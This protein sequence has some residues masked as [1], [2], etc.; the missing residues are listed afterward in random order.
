MPFTIDPEIGAVLAAFAQAGA[1][2]PPAVGDIETRVNNFLAGFNPLI[3][4]NYPAIPSIVTKDYHIKSADGHELLAR[5]YTKRGSNP[6]SAAI[7]FHSGGMIMGDVPTF[8]GFVSNYVERSGV[9]FL[10]VDYRLAPA[11]PYPK[12][13]EDA[14]ASLVWLH[15]HA[16]ELGVD[17]KRII[18]HGDSAGGCLAASLAIYNRE[19]KGPAIA[20]Q[21][22]VYPMLDDRSLTADEHIAPYLTWGAADNETGWKA[23]LGSKFGSADVPAIAAPSRL[24]DPTGLPPLYVEVGELDLFREEDIAYVGKFQKAGINAELHVFPGAPHGTCIP[25]TVLLK[26]GEMV[27]RAVHGR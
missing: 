4:A 8:D 16:K 21:I 11:H 17:P 26:Q 1:P 13:L 24:T 18:I 6:G 3:A 10:S 22:L 23:Y 19:K 12:A 15:E 14:F 7:Y 25:V 20:K 9:P 2:P 27:N 5:W